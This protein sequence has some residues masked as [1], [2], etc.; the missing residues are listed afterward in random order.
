MK[1]KGMIVCAFM[2]PGILFG[3]HA[4]ALDELYLCGIVREVNIRDSQVTVDVSSE[5]C[6]GLRKFMLPA[7]KAGAAFKV[8][9]RKCFYIDSNRCKPGYIH[10]ITKI[11]P[12]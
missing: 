2:F 12:E 6:R 4:F 5:S 3:T 9:N 7:G 8:N 11:A 10:A 1:L